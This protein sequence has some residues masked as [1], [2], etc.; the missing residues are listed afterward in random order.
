[1][2]APAAPAPGWLAGSVQSTL[3][4]QAQAWLGLAIAAVLLSSMGPGPA[5]LVHYSLIAVILYVALTNG[6]R[7]APAIARFN[8]SLGLT[9]RGVVTNP[10]GSR[11]AGGSY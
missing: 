10:D 7:F 9:A 8:R 4:A 11:V 3:G 2:S 6:Q 5:G 1:M